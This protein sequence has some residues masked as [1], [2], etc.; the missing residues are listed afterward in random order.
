MRLFVRDEN[1][2]LIAQKP[3]I[4]GEMQSNSLGF[5]APRDG[6]YRIGIES[7]GFSVWDLN[8]RYE[9]NP[10]EFLTMGRATPFA[11]TEVYGRCLATFCGGRQVYARGEAR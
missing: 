11:G 2:V 8:E 9:I 4:P 5:S 7:D 1:D 6:N 10:S 3:L